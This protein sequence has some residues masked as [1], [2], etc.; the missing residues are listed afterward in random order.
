MTP[1]STPTKQVPGLYHHRL[2]DLTITAV[3]DDYLPFSFDY[4]THIDP[5]EA[6][7]LSAAAF[8]IDPP[9]LTVNAFAIHTPEGV[10]LVDSGGGAMVGDTL[11]HMPANLALAGVD[12]SEVTAILLTHL[13]PDHAG[14]LVDA[15]GNARYPN[16]ELV[17]HP[18]EAAF[19]LSPGAL[20]NAPEAVKP[21]VQMAQTATAPYRS[22]LRTLSSGEARP[23]IAIVPEPGHTPGHSGWMI[24][25]GGQKLLIWGD[26]VHLPG[27]QFALPR[28]GLAFDANV[29]QA[30][31]TRLQILGMAATDRLQVAGMHLDFPPFGHV[32]K[33]GQTYAFTPLTWSPVL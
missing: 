17:M 15:A 21:S 32:Q 16:A 25:S 2:G 10:V 24:S 18:A 28:I 3:N 8:R 31:Q 19:W 14:G 26:I 11:G 5:P 7:K 20:A 6:A 33:Q 12:P 4:V 23:G 13:H 9:R 30:H 22:R 29:D 27:L 1:T